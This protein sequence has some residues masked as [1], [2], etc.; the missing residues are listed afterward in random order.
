MAKDKTNQYI[1]LR[2]QV[3]GYKKD[4]LFEWQLIM[5]NICE[6]YNTLGTKDQLHIW[7]IVGTIKSYLLPNC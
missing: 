5:K 6:I 4:Q 3:L 1:I 7:T 2:E